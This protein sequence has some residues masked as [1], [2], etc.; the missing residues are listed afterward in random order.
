MK[1]LLLLTAGVLASL[2]ALAAPTLTADA[3]PSTGVQPATA[4]LTVNG[5]AGPACTLPKA[6]DGSVK[7][8][9]DLASLAPSATPY[10]LVLTYNYTA[11]CVNTPTGA[12]CTDGGAA[13]SAPFSF[14]RAAK[15]AA[16]SNVQVSPQ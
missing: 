5:A 14:T 12:V 9:C 10:T 3:V 6:A 2:G 4:T 13:A 1:K 15:G 8:S 7:P 11:G 16:P